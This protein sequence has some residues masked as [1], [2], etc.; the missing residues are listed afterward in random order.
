M[1]TATFKYEN[2]STNQPNYQLPQHCDYED[3]VEIQTGTKH[4]D[5]YRYSAINITKRK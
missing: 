5:P 2:G 3:E 4:D 1:G